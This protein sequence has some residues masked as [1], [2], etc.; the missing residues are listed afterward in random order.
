MMR[1]AFYATRETVSAL[2]AR[3]LTDRVPAVSDRD[4]VGDLLEFANA[5]GPA[6]DSTIAHAISAAASTDQLLTNASG[7]KHTAIADYTRETA[8]IVQ[9]WAAAELAKIVT[10]KGSFERL[11]SA[12][13]G[14]GADS[15]FNGPIVIE[16]IVGGARRPRA[17]RRYSFLSLEEFAQWTLLRI[18]D[19]AIATRLC[20][21]HFEDCQHFF[22]AIDSG[23]RVRRKYC[24]DKCLD[25]YYR[26]TSAERVAKSR[27]R[28]KGKRR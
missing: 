16:R 26:K 2:G 19:R 13:P 12:R 6:L 21:C 1:I 20:R 11:D 7:N 17:E 24:S 22:L 4:L 23:G 27:A 9:R 5:K 25:E 8:P 14:V 10:G 28:R 15:P 18:R 3:M